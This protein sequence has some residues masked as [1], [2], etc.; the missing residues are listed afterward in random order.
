MNYEKT[1]I[2]PC[3]KNQSEEVKHDDN[4][5]CNV[6]ETDQKKYSVNNHYLQVRANPPIRFA[7][8]SGDKNLLLH[9]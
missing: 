9:G 5:V 6:N 3:T 1:C 4:E 2:A 7:V 8:W